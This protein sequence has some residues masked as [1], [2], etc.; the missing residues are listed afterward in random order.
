MTAIIDQVTKRFEAQTVLQELNLKI[1]AGEIFVIVGPSGS[2]KTTTLKMIN[3]LI[4]LQKAIFIKD[5][6]IKDYN[7]QNCATN[8]YVLQQIA[9][10]PPCR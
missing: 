8:G 2:G 9:L 1:E 4:D 6:R 3:G 5:K 10:F 7:L